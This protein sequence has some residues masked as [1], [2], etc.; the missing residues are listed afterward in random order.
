MNTVTFFNSVSGVG[1]STLVYH[2]AHMLA[3]QGEG[4]IVADLDPQASLTSMFLDE[5]ALIDLWPNAE[6]SRTVYGAVKPAICGGGDVGEVHYEE[7]E[8]GIG[9]L[10]GDPSVSLLEDSLS[11]AWERCQSR[12]ES[13]IRAM[14]AF[15]SAILDGARQFNATWIL[16]N[17]GSGLGAINRSALIASE[18]VVVPLGADLFSLQALS[19]VGP[20]F[21]EWRSSWAAIG[22]TCPNKDFEIPAEQI[23]PLGYIVLQPGYRDNRPSK[24]YKWINKIPA[25]YRRWVLAESDFALPPP[26]VDDPHCLS[27][28]KHYR[29]L[30]PMAAEA[31]KPVFALTPADGAIGAHGAAVRSAGED[32]VRLAHILRQRIPGNPEW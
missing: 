32:F 14:L 30:M 24:V 10:V 3:D 12:D 20:T 2:L 19:C 26:T 17:V 22:A 5:D 23:N 9:L 21:Q 8:R 7:V 4:V 11:D 15:R 16:I 31:R 29:S 25:E 18:Y 6:H 27:V 1:R 28:I 13:G